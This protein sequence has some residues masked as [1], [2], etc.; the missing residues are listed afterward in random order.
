MKKVFLVVMV[1][2]ISLVSCHGVAPDAGEEAVLI[3]KPWIFGSGGVVAT[4][5]ET[6]LTW[7]FMS[8]SSETFNIKPVQMTETF[9][10]VITSDNV[11]VDFKAYISLQII[12]G[13]TPILYE[14]FGVEW[15]NNNVKEP[16]RTLLRNYSKQQKL[17][18]LTTDA[19]VLSAGEV[20]VEAQIK[21]LIKRKNI[22]V[23]VIK[24]TIGKISPPA[25][26][27]KE[28]T[29]TAAEKQKTRTNIEREIAEKTRAGAEKQSAIADKAY[30]K[31]FGMSVDQYLEFKKLEL[32]YAQLEV[33]KLKG[34]NVSMI[35]NDG[36]IPTVP[37]K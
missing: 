9:D 6:D 12:K 32:G 3:K 19:T 29:K 7:C 1:L 24:V 14:N 34:S 17:F 4:P 21:D 37:I 13:E 18:E 25:D 35:F 8:T 22:P 16:F 5:V 23:K 26:V 33:A 11:P 36:A 27:T 30:Q 31:E 20:E 15:Y 2:A 10:D 28:T